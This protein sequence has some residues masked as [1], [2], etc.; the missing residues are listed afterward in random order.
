M[1]DIS[2]YLFT[3]QLFENQDLS[4]RD[5]LEAV[6]AM[7][8]KSIWGDSLPFNFESDDLQD[9]ETEESENDD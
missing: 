6:E 9:L 8:E 4:E 3:K 2:T 5:I 7:Y 1:S